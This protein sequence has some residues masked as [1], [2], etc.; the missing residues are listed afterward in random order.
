MKAT[1]SQGCDCGCNGRIKTGEQFEIVD[2]YFYAQGHRQC[3]PE[4]VTPEAIYDA[5][6]AVEDP[7]PAVWEQ[8]EQAQSDETIQLSLF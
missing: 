8:M 5:I 2:G 6:Q 4:H 3:R 7:V 1:K